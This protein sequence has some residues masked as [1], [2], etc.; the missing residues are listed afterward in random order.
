MD[1]ILNAEKLISADVILV[2]DD[3][4]EVDD[5]EAIRSNNIDKFKPSDD[6]ILLASKLFVGAGF[7]V[8]HCVGISVS[9]TGPLSLFKQVFELDVVENQKGGFAFVDSDQSE[10]SELPHKHIPKDL[11]GIV[12]DVVFPSPLDFGPTDFGSWGM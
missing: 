3:V 4:T 5:H 8:G 9:I 10:F 11:K 2:P 1:A 12:K 7:T 6:A